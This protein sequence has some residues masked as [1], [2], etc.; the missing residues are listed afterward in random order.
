[1]RK[2]A[3]AVFLVGVIAE[4]ALAQEDV[5]GDYLCTISEKAGIASLHL[6]DADPPAAFVDR[7]L[8]TRFRMR[9]TDDGDGTQRYRAFEIEYEGEDRDP[10]SWHTNNSILHSHYFGDRNLFYA[11]DDPAFFALQPTRHTNSDG[12]L[13]FYHA[14]FEYPGGVDTELTV[15]WGRCRKT[16]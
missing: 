9:I 5:L 11:S 4:P 2:F 12:D 1:M 14:G 7:Y 8:P 16:N 6:E 3:T 15:R 10:R 13:S